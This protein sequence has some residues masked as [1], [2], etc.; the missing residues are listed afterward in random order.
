MPPPS[1][2]NSQPIPA[3][4]IEVIPADDW[5]VRESP[6]NYPIPPFFQ[7][8]P[9]RRRI[10]LPII[11]FCATCLTTFGIAFEP[12]ASAGEFRLGFLRAFQYS[13][14]LM[15]IL[16]CHEMG[17]FL[18]SLRYKIPASLPFFIP[19]PL[20]PFGTMG[21]V[22][23]MKSRLGSR[24]SLFDVGISGP[25]AGLIPTLI[26]CIVGIHWSTVGK[27][28]DP[29]HIIPGTLFNDPL[30]F[31]WLSEWILGP[32]PRGKCMVFHPIAFA[33]W[34]GLFITSLNLIPVG[35]LDGGH[36]LYALLRRKSYLV[37]RLLLMTAVFFIVF[38]FKNY[39]QW[40][41]LLFLLTFIGIYHPPTADDYEELGWFRTLLGIAILL[42][43]PFGFTPQPFV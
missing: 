12:Y 11:L 24:K 40:S 2:D 17:H 27:T 43:I 18:Q 41:V 9:R 19:M 34:V 25:L 35:Q 29:E 37:V 32:I 8:P 5:R 31:Q 4:V 15:T 6:A 10:Y 21:A 7:P 20:P 13:G 30:I 26:C 23:V 33:G 3:E 38:D 28:P 22:I 42:F 39:W 16:F 36:V 14:C 1:D